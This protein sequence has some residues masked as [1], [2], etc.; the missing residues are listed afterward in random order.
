MTSIHCPECSLLVSGSEQNCPQCNFPIS[1]L[2]GLSAAILTKNAERV[3]GL[4]QLGA[5]VN[6]VDKNGRTPLMTAALIDDAEI[7]QMLLA[8]GARPQV[9]NNAGE[10]ALS[11]AKSRDV[12]RLIRRAIVVSKFQRS[13]T[14][15]PQPSKVQQEPAIEIEPPQKPKPSEHPVVEFDHSIML[16]EI[17]P[18][19]QRNQAAPIDV[20]MN[21]ELFELQTHKVHEEFTEPFLFEEAPPTQMNRIMPVDVQMNDELFESLQSHKVQEPPEPVIFEETPPQPQINQ[22]LPVDVQM[23]EE[24]FEPDQNQK[25]YEQQLPEPVVVERQEVVEMPIEEPPVN[26]EQ[27]VY[28]EP[29]YM[30][31]AVIDQQLVTP[32]GPKYYFAA[33]IGCCLLLLFMALTWPQYTRSAIPAAAETPKPMKQITKVEPEKQPPVQKTEPKVVIEQPVQQNE[34]DA[35][36]PEVRKTEIEVAEAPQM[37]AP[38]PRA[39]AR[40]KAIHSLPKINS[41]PKPVEDLGNI[42]LAR[43][44]NSQGYSLI[45]QGKFGEAIP[46]LE[47]SLQSFPKDTK[48]AHYG[49]ALYNLALAWR[50]AGRPDLAIPI[51]EKRLQIADQRDIVARDL[52]AARQEAKDAGFGSFRN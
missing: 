39:P 2:R 7:V 23:N 5:D 48:D 26:E 38:I 12:E 21:D 50:K 43:A 8:A 34:P 27:P 24:L 45:K 18:P 32:E 28:D 25:L 49:Y 40:K 10:T 13:Q 1:K 11:L 33:I 17:P 37:I 41:S 51:L 20:Q 19:T 47:R 22:Q 6:A 16:T 35:V 4:I 30:E 9:V 42:R 3:A 46:V 44:L 15:S 14:E 29:I 52:Y 36:P 31:P